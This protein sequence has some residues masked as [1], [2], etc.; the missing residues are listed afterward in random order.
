MSL[1]TYF[2]TTIKPFR[3]RTLSRNKKGILHAKCQRG[4]CKT[5]RRYVQ[6]FQATKLLGYYPQDEQTLSESS[7]FMM[8][9][10]I[11][12]DLPMLQC[13]GS[14]MHTKNIGSA[15]LR[16]FMHSTVNQNRGSHLFSQKFF[17]GH[18]ISPGILR[19]FS[20]VNESC[21]LQP[22]SF[23]LWTAVV[24]VAT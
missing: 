21:T 23:R 10:R 20:G 2:G 6:H 3:R 16:S 22:S 19:S 17:W 1:P 7:F 12:F 8:A 13:N 15:Q 24:F 11:G 9:G 5:K 18:N 14:G 4:K